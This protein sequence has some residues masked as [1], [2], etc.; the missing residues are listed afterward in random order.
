MCGALTYKD[1]LQVC[2]SVFV[3]VCTYSWE[4]NSASRSGKT[5]EGRRPY[6]T[7]AGFRFITYSRERREK[8]RGKVSISGGGGGEVA[9]TLGP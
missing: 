7:A 8:G 1:A 3:P 5:A 6:V 2:L 4:G 9:N